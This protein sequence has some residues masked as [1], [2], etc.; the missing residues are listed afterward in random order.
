MTASWE[1]PARKP[2]GKVFVPAPRSTPMLYFA[3][4]VVPPSES[5]KPPQGAV[6]SQNLELNIMRG[7]VKR[8]CLQRRLDRFQITRVNRN[9]QKR[10]P[11]Q[12]RNSKQF[13]GYIIPVHC[14]HVR[15]EAPRTHSNTLKQRGELFLARGQKKNVVG[16]FLRNAVKV[17]VSRPPWY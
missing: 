13:S 10:N 3:R 4:A 8:R 14:A 12:C 16:R 11:D 6:R 9:V 17:H 15:V 5:V 2:K 1:A 7:V